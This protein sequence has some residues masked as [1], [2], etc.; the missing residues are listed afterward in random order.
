MEK[1]LLLTIVETRFKGWTDKMV[2]HHATPMV[3]I[4][5]GHGDVSG[6]ICVVCIE[7]FSNEQLHDLIKKTLDALERLQK[8]Q[9]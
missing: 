5:I 4:G 6:Q 3:C 1:E 8:K 2:G 9:T 7:E